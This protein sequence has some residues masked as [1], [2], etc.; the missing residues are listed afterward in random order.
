[1]ALSLFIS[2][3]S[4]SNGIFVTDKKVLKDFPEL[5]PKPVI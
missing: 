4:L 5:N 2:A 1:M 3:L